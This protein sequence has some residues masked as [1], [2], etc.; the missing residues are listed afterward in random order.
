MSSKELKIQACIVSV[1]LGLI[2]GF[3]AIPKE[4]VKLVLISWAIICG[5]IL[6]S[7]EQRSVWKIY[8]SSIAPSLFLCSTPFIVV[9]LRAIIP[10]FSEAGPNFYAFM[11]FL[12]MMRH[13]EVY[14]LTYVAEYIAYSFSLATICIFLSLIFKNYLYNITDASLLTTKR[15]ITTSSCFG[16]LSLLFI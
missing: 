15:I 1:L 7:D 9:P 2:F 5:F 12:A 3:S 14:F 11:S 10:L 8:T 16:V 6:S 13:S 4:Y